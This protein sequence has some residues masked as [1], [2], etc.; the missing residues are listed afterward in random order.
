MQFKQ[1]FPRIQLFCGYAAM[2]FMNFTMCSC[3]C[4]LGG[5]AP[6]RIPELVFKQQTSNN[7]PQGN[8]ISLNL[9]IDIFQMRMLT[10]SFPSVSNLGQMEGHWGWSTSC[11][12]TLALLENTQ[13]IIIFSNTKLIWFDYSR[14]QSS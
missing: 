6:C 12:G 13:N 8:I 4:S 10:T 1:S 14:T 9:W 2:L 3:R 5:R 11:W 7:N